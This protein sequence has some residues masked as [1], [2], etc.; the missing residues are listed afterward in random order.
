MFCR[1]VV[2]CKF[3]APLVCAH[4]VCLQDDG[5]TSLWLASQEGHEPV[6]RTLLSF[7]AAV[8]QARTVSCYCVRAFAVCMTCRI[9]CAH[10][11][12]ASSW[13]L[14]RNCRRPV[15]DH[16][17]PLVRSDMHISYFLPCAG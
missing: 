9:V 4:A 15:W 8:N 17:G 14:M 2:H 7:G 12:V 3:L 5:V 6:V 11:S 16:D 1:I 13:V 10:C